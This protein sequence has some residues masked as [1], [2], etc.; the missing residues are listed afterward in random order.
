[1]TREISQATSVRSLIPFMKDQPSL[2]NPFWKA[3]HPNTLTLGIRSQHMNFGGTHNLD[4]S[5]YHNKVPQTRQLSKTAETYENSR[6]WKSGPRSLKSRCTEELQCCSSWP[7]GFA[8]YLQH[9]SACSCNISVS[10][11]TQHDVVPCVSV[12][13]YLLLFLWVY[14]PPPVW[15]CLI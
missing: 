13:V 3:P 2:L 12:S 8:G 6:V 15:P 9:F 7:L 11:M 5:S 14:Y 10:S 4:N 1:M